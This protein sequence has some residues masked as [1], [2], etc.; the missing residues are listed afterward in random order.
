[1][2]ALVELCTSKLKEADLEINALVSRFT[3]VGEPVLVICEVQVRRDAAGYQGGVGA[4]INWLVDLS[5]G[6]D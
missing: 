3:D 4:Y 1:M 6:G 2:T 5:E